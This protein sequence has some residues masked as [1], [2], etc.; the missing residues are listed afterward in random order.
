MSTIALMIS[1]VV[2]VVLIVCLFFKSALNEI[3]KEY[4]RN[5]CN[6]KNERNQRVINLRKHLST[7]RDSVTSELVAMAEWMNAEEP[8][9]K[10]KYKG[11]L[12]ALLKLS[13]GSVRSIRDNMIYYPDNIKSALEVFFSEYQKFTGEIVEKPMYKERLHEMSDYLDS[14]IGDII[15]MIDKQR[16]GLIS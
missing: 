15:E 11:D 6:R 7:I 14:S 2:N 10:A 5:K 13:G 4:W 9:K 16:S 8:G 1:L 12:K 3:L